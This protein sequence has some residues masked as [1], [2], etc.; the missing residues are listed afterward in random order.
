MIYT[1]VILW[2]VMVSVRTAI[3]KQYVSSAVHLSCNNVFATV[4][5]HCAFRHTNYWTAVCSNCSRYDSISCSKR[6]SSDAMDTTV[7][8]LR[9]RN[10]NSR[11]WRGGRKIPSRTSSS[12]GKKVSLVKKLLLLTFLVATI[13]NIWRRLVTYCSW[14]RD[15]SW[16]RTNLSAN[17][18]CSYK[19]KAWTELVPWLLRCQCMYMYILIKNEVFIQY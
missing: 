6:Q 17:D 3:S 5:N 18:P 7:V 2:F 16:R 10:F 1:S 19:R 13:F 12:E 11:C 15:F 4:Q 14:H 9:G 8:W